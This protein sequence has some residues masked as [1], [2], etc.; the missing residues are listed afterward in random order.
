[1]PTRRV[2]SKGFSYIIASSFPKLRGAR[3]VTVPAG[4]SEV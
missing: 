4:I 3:S 1:L 2:P